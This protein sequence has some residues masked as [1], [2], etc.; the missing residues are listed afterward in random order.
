MSRGILFRECQHLY[1]MTVAVKA[2]DHAEKM[3][4]GPTSQGIGILGSSDQ[5]V[6]DGQ[7][8]AGHTLLPHTPFRENGGTLGGDEGILQQG[9]YSKGLPAPICGQ[10]FF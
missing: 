3:K 6:H 4:P 2:L 10:A 7:S 8:Q 1:R 5:N 9:R